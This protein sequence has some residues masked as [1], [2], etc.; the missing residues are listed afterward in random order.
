MS[1][2]VDWVLDQLQSVVNNQP[3]DH[4]LKR[5]D[6]D[7][8]ELLEGSIRDREADLQ[9]ANYVGATLAERAGQA[10]GTEFN[11]RVE[12]VVGLRIEGAHHSEYGHIDP[13]TNDGVDFDA[14]VDDIKEALWSG[15]KFPA[16]G[17]EDTSYHT[18]YVENEAPQS[19][20]Y[21]D[22]YRYDADVRFVGYRTLPDA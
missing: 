11:R 19:A 18:L 9:H 1:A 6:R 12:T 13:D 4:P 16:V 15:R 10:L 17:R 3:A 21:S 2:E 20:Q 14:L 7:E 8:S 22:Y 5:I